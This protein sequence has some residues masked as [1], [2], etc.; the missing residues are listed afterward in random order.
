MSRSCPRCGSQRVVFCNYGKR[1]G[2]YVGTVAGGM[3]GAATSTATGALALGVSVPGQCLAPL[4][5]PLLAA[6]LACAWA[7]W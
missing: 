6:L 1:I 7:S 4:P 3:T 2:G 5:V